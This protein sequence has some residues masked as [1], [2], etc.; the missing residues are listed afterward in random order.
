M[1]LR[2]RATTSLEVLLPRDAQRGHNKSIRSWHSCKEKDASP[3]TKRVTGG[4]V[5]RKSHALTLA[6]G[7]RL[8][9]LSVFQIDQPHQHTLVQLAEA[10]A[11]QARADAGIQGC[12]I[13][14]AIGKGDVA[15][16]TQWLN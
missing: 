14:R 9:G 15:V 13:F 16:F 6:P 8:S 5:E 11:K 2:G 12:A 3:M 4:S 10:T 7:E 1:L